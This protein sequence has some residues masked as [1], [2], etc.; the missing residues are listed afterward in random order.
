[1]IGYAPVNESAYRLCHAVRK[2]CDLPAPYSGS[3][4]EGVGSGPG[5]RLPDEPP[6][7]STRLSLARWILPSIKNLLAHSTSTLLRLITEDEQGPA[8][9]N[10]AQQGQ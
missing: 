2:A 7:R 9:S 5:D 6:K 4:K 10:K 1:M 8:S 3:A